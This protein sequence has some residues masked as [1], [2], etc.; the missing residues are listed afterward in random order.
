MNETGACVFSIWT[1]LLF[2]LLA[3]LTVPPAGVKAKTRSERRK[4]GHPRRHRVTI[5]RRTRQG[6]I[7]MMSQHRRI[8]RLSVSHPGKEKVVPPPY[9]PAMR[10]S[11]KGR[12]L[13]FAPF[14]D[15]GQARTSAFLKLWRAHIPT[16]PR[17]LFALYGIWFRYGLPSTEV[18]T[19]DRTSITV[20][21]KGAPTDRILIYARRFGVRASSTRGAVRI[22]LR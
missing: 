8:P 11:W 6:H 22:A 1:A 13:T 7:K 18:L 9:Y 12:T 17:V 10:L 21:M 20:R 19:A 14:Y 5:T 3:V 15:N 16:H 4:A 2:V